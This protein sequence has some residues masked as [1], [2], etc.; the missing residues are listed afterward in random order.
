MTGENGAQPLDRGVGQGNQGGLVLAAARC[1]TASRSRKRIHSRFG[2]RWGVTCW[3]CWAG[4]WYS[5]ELYI[6]YRCCALHH[7]EE[8]KKTSRPPASVGDRLL[9]GLVNRV[10]GGND[11]RAVPK[12]RDRKDVDVPFCS[13][14]V[15]CCGP[16]F[17]FWEQDQC[18]HPFINC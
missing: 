5:M 9:V 7:P 6:Q 17:F 4:L 2:V 16:T 10:K 18:I 12:I 14:V 8:D 13:T 3:G 15:P 11:A 1:G